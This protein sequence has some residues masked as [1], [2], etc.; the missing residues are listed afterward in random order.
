MSPE[1]RLDILL[2]APGRGGREIPPAVDDAALAPLLSAVG[3][4]REIGSQ[5]PR[6]AFAL[7]LERRLLAHA[8]DLARSDAYAPVP[9]GQPAR[10]APLPITS[11]RRPAPWWQTRLAQAVAAAALLLVGT[12]GLLTAGAMAAPGSPLFGLHRWEQ[13]VRVALD[14]SAADRARLHLQY[15]AGALTALD[16]EV[17]RNAG[18]GSY[19]DALSTVRDEDGAAEHDIAAVTP[20]AEHD[21][22]AAQLS[23]LRQR[24]HTSLRAALKVPLEWSS[25]IQTTQALG[26]LG[27]QIPM[28]SSVTLDHTGSGDGHIWRIVLVGSGYL[29]GA[30]L[31]ADGRPVGT[32]QSVTATRLVAIWTGDDGGLSAGDLGVLNPDGTAASAKAIQRDHGGEDKV[33]SPGA[34]GTPGKGD[35]RDGHGGQGSGEDA[36]PAA[37]ATGQPDPTVEPSE[38]PTPVPSHH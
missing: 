11:A 9:Q 31:V 8:S 19:R 35:G 12:G 33:P 36:T 5:E 38:S 17:A 1:D 30:V 24:E 7:D 13:G 20:G 23:G 18:G 28:I 15:L 10:R 16:G 14:T 27:E 29:P 22:L 37:T 34:G 21:S 4:L 32:V 2:S 3:R 6:S 26:G 25:R